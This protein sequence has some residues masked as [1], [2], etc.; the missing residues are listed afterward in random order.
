[1]PQ[2]TLRPKGQLTIPS[3]IIKAWNLKP[4][5]QIEI[6]FHNG[7]V[8]LVPAKKEILEDSEAEKKLLS[9]AG[10]GKGTWGKNSEEIQKTIREL[11]DSWTR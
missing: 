1:M 7:V 8:T 11:R 3:E 4:Y 2:A 10:I 9:F 5:D 6:V